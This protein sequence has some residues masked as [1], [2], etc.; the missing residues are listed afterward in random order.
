MRTP[1]LFLGAAPVAVFVTDDGV[2]V[3]AQMRD[4]LSVDP[5]REIDRG[6]GQYGGG[7]SESVRL[8]LGAR[9]G[10]VQ[11]V[12]SWVSP[13]GALRERYAA[14]YVHGRCRERQRGCPAAG[15]RGRAR[16]SWG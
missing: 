9:R 12:A 5:A 10:G 7:I 15:T 16:D 8:R 4:R 1:I 14:R 6:L 11:R 3:D 13:T 2:D